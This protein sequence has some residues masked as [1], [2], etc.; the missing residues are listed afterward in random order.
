M[1]AC[2][3][4]SSLSRLRCCVALPLALALT[5]LVA[6]G[7]ACDPVKLPHQQPGPIGCGKRDPRGTAPGMLSIAQKE[8]MRKNG[9]PDEVR[10]N[11]KGG[12]DWL[13]HRSAGSVFGEQ[14]TVEILR[15]DVEGILVDQQTE[16][17]MKVG[18]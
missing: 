12:L 4:F 7:L 11:D 8:A 9:S 6:L 2:V 3:R 1:F 13:Y 5:P 14:K 15:F 18:K 17:L 10:D 16:V